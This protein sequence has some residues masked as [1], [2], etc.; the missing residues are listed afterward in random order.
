M[1]IT[2]CVLLHKDCSCGKK[3]SIRHDMEGTRYIRNCK[4][5]GGGEDIFED[6][7]RAL[8]KRG[9]NPGDIL[10]SESSERGN[11]VGIIWNELPIEV[12]KIEK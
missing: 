11:N 5:R 12:C 6:V 4:D 10:A 3:G 9:P 2:V 1:D 8:V 7:E